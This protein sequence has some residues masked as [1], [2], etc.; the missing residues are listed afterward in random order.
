MRRNPVGPTMLTCAV[1]GELL[2][3]VDDG[4]TRLDP[5]TGATLGVLVAANAGG[6]AGATFLALIPKPVALPPNTVAEFH[7]GALDPFITADRTR[8]RDR[9]RRRRA[10]GRA[11]ARRFPRAARPR[12][13]GSTAASRR[14]SLALHT[15]DA[16][17]CQALQDLQAA[18]R[19]RPTSG[20]TSGSNDFLS[21][22]ARRRSGAAQADTHL[23]RLQQRLRPRH[24][25]R[26]P[27]H[28][29]TG[30]GPADHR[31]WLG[32]EGVVMCAPG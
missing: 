2:I 18:L 27:D 30:R 32:D 25:Q 3:T 20:G 19:R 7:N 13:A 28:H 29:L 6:L 24:R 12:C 5:E 15:V 17:E 22:P 4:V 11:P 16:A 9:Q 14:D 21:T 10:A 26:P 23:P 31:A 1:D 8:W